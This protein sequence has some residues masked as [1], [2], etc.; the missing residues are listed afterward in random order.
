MIKYLFPLA[1]LATMFVADQGFAAGNPH[2]PKGGM[3]ASSQAVVNSNGARSFDRDRG[4]DRPA[5]RRN[6]RSTVKT[7]GHLKQTLAKAWN[8][9]AAR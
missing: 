5:E 8:P 2:G 4:F 7:R 1:V 6:V 9:N 3:P